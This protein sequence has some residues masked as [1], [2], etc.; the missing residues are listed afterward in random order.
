MNNGFSSRRS[1]TRFFDL[2][3][4]IS[5]G[6]LERILCIPGGWRRCAHVLSLI[7]PSRKSYYFVSIE[8][9][10]ASVGS[11]GSHQGCSSRLLRAFNQQGIFAKCARQSAPDDPGKSRAIRDFFSFLL[12]TGV[13]SSRSS[14]AQ[15][16]MLY[17]PRDQSRE[18]CLIIPRTHIQTPYSIKS[19][20]RTTSKLVAKSVHVR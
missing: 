1:P 15:C 2:V 4:N 12:W 11:V 6:V 5:R 3:I 9:Y 17:S 14:L 18:L 19:Q 7:P 13:R 16:I 20:T 10:E 8:D